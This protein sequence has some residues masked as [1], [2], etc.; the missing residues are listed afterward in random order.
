MCAINGF[1]FEDQALVERMNRVTAH[2]GPDRS[3]T[4]VA[5]GVSLG[6]NRLAI[7]DLSPLGAQPMK[8]ADGR[9]II[10]FNGEIYNYRELREQLSSYP[11]KSE[12][13]TEVI[14]AAYQRWGK[15]AFA[16]L[17]GIFALA[18]FDL[19]TR[20]VL[21]VRDTAGVKPL[22]YATTDRGLVFSSEIKGL[23][24][25]PLPRTLNREAFL[26]Y[27]RVLYVPAPLT[28]FEGVYKLLSGTILTYR[29]G[30]VHTE[31]FVPEVASDYATSDAS[32]TEV[33]DRAVDRQMVSDRPLGIYLSGGLDSSIVLDAAS[34]THGSIDT[35]SVGFDLGTNHPRTDEFNADAL[36]ARKTAAHYGARHHEVFLRTEEVPALF[37]EMVWHLDEPIANA[38]TIPM[39]KLAKFAKEHVTVALG[40]D[41]GDELFGG[42]PR[43]R[44]SLLASTFQQ[45]P[46]F[47]TTSL[48][49]MDS[50]V[51]KL[52]EPAGIARFKQFLF[53]KD[54][55]LE[56]VLTDTSDLA[57]TE[58]FFRKQ[59][60]NS[61]AQ[62]FEAQFMKADR[63][64]WLVDESLM[65]T[66]KMAMA[67]AVEVRV[68]FLDNEVIAFADRLP[69]SEKVSL[70]ETKR[71]LRRAF[72]GRLPEYLYTQPKRGWFSPGGEWVKMEP[73]SSFV[74][75]I[76]SP[77]YYQGSK[78]L[79]KFDE[80]RAM[81]SAHRSQE[82][83][84]MVMLWALLVF[85]VWMR[86][87]NVTV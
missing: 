13:D 49:Y 11:F 7:I 22:Y 23:L 60:F 65:R 27:L 18:L 16:K 48:G 75:E 33:I 19:E 29:N 71:M 87:Y 68:P 62:D 85:Q 50:R 57:V 14:L 79:F 32:L 64:S 61:P 59:F 45:L 63:A 35:F 12:S 56:R 31:S 47:L 83:Y 80:V 53:Q 70:F 21:L 6:H 26:H 41:G 9:Y 4:L 86:K 66:D 3:D 77:S 39:L 10:T 69:T 78:E 46:S 84:H 51:K 76:L 74:N 2:R 28:M 82:E 34:R 17:N 44:L 1:T 81:L 30:E 38:T 67:A 43:Y 15:Q 72:R 24:E 58:E 55:A 73:F 8:S 37:E 25:H 40:G 52:N 54:R 20:D 42:Y 36:L 5:H